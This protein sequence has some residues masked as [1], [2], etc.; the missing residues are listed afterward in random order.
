[1]RRIEG[2]QC[3]SWTITGEKEEGE[4]DACPVGERLG[5]QS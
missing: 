4:H 1:M 2:K 3:Y 5:Q